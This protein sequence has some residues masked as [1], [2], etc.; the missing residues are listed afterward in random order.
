M[1]LYLSKTSAVKLFGCKMYEKLNISSWSSLQNCFFVYVLRN[2][3]G[4]YKYPQQL[5]Q[6][7][8]DSA[9]AGTI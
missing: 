8:T 3:E 5:K 2:F 6:Q 7:E 9:V 4:F 1:V